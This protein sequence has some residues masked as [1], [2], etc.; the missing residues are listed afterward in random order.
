MWEMLHFDAEGK[1]ASG[2]I[3]YD[4]VTMLGQLGHIDLP[5]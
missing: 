5:G 2:Q 1:V 3:M 4:Q